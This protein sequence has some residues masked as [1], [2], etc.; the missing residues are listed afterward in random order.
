[1][2]TIILEME[3]ALDKTKN[4]LDT[5]EK[6]VVNLNTDNKIFSK[7]NIEEKMKGT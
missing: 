4:K 2:K 1:M 7:F 3:N 5:I 6:T